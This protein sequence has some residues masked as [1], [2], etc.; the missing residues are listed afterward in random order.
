MEKELGEDLHG[1][2]GSSAGPNKEVV[3]QIRRACL[4]HAG[5]PKGVKKRVGIIKKEKEN[6]QHRQ[7]QV[8]QVP[9]VRPA[10][11]LRGA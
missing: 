7:Q 4:K 10:G 2:L 1:I 9:Q 5:Q 8:G 11:S 6:Q 3:A